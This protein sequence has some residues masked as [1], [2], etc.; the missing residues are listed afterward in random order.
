MP[1]GDEP[2][3]RRPPDE[4]AEGANA[5]AAAGHDEDLAD[6]ALLARPWFSIR[7]KIILAFAV[8]AALNVSVTV[9]ASWSI[10]EVQRRIRFLEV[11]SSYLREL[12]EVRRYEKNYLL[13]GSDL[14]EARRHLKNAERVLATERGRIEEILGPKRHNTL[15][16]HVGDYDFMLQQ[17]DRT[18]DPEQRAVIEQRL[19]DHG[20][21][22]VAY[23]MELAEKERATVEQRLA[24]AGRVPVFFGGVLLALMI[25]VAY[26]LARQLLNPLSRF[27]AHAERIGLGDFSPIQPTRKHRDEFSQLALAFNHMIRELDHRHRVLTESHKLR[28][29]GTLVAGVAHE[30]NNPLNNVMLTSALLQE[31][32]GTLD[33]KAKLEM[34]GDLLNETERAQRIVRNLLDFARESETKVQPI[35]IE[36][37]IEESIRLVGNQIKLA[38]VKVETEVPSDLPAVHGDAQMLKQVFVNLLLNA[39]EAMGP[40]TGRSERAWIRV[41]VERDVRK[42]FLAVRVE[43]NGPGIPEHLVTRIF[44]PFFTTKQRRKGTG[45][46]L[47]VSQGIVRKLGGHIEVESRVGAGTTFTVFLPTTEMPSSL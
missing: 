17:I 8:F 13:Y 40:G 28:A 26:F 33:D 39:V 7:A 4:P 2:V 10:S 23:A 19:R 16:Q 38:K 42:A 41:R 32:Y 25:V 43:D 24:L 18:T 1:A 12:Q 47:S 22:I 31:E 29:I 46:G 9:W 35:R 30:L 27:M 37:T 5:G 36:Q 34:I 21:E 14:A 44:D 6:R 11:T 15:V 20:S 45:L 3:A